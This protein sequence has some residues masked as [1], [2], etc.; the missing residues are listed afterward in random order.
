MPV[1]GDDDPPRD[2]VPMSIQY[3]VHAAPPY[4]RYRCLRP[5][6]KSKEAISVALT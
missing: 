2:R 5:M 1:R 4:A 6:T 3:G